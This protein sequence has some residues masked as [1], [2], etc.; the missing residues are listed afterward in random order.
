MRKNWFAILIAFV[1]VMAMLA[2][3]TAYAAESESGNAGEAVYWT[4]DNKGVLTISGRGEIT[5]APWRGDYSRVIKEVIIEEGIT[6]ISASAAFDSLTSLVRVSLPNTLTK[7]GTDAFEYCSSLE[8]IVLP[9]SV[10]SLGGW[11]FS[12][13]TSLKNVTMPSKLPTFGGAC[14]SGCPIENVYITDLYDWCSVDFSG[15]GLEYQNLILNGRAVT[16]LEIPEGIT[17]I[18]NYAFDYWIG[19]ETVT[20]PSS[21]TSI[22]TYAFRGCENLREV[23]LSNGITALHSYVFAECHSLTKLTLPESIL[24]LDSNVF[25]CN[26]YSHGKTSSITELRFLGDAPS[27]ASDA[28]TS[29]T[30]TIAYSAQNPTWT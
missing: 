25:V 4:L 23:N 14:F 22:G 26:N 3:P 30:A 18:S 7:I 6:A 12:Q 17:S 5:S 2:F 20:V 28:F 16:D 10:T 19:L 29:V 27:I 11:A 15:M 13:C 8:S 9:D 24:V 1:A 21:V